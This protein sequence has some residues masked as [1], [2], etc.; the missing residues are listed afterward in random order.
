MITLKLYLEYTNSSKLYNEHIQ[1]IREYNRALVERYPWLGIKDYNDFDPYGENK[2]DSYDWTWL[3]DMPDGWRIAFG[4]QMCDEIQKELERV[5]FVD[6]YRIVQVKEKYG[7]LRWY[8]GGVPV[9]SKLD[10]I[11]RKYEFLS[12]NTCIKCG[13]PATWLS[14]GWISPYCN[15]CKEKLA[16]KINCIE[17]KFVP[18]KR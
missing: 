4:E 16:N 15:E 5:D 2:P 12:E 6:E 1:E 9:N 8:T 14:A 10:D 3:D 17:K 11:A 13:Q 7:G 18:I